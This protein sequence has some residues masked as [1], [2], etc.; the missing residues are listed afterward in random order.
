MLTRSAKY[1]YDIHAIVRIASMHALPELSAFRVEKLSAQPDIIVRSDRAPTR[2][3][4]GIAGS[5]V[6]KIVKYHDGLARLGFDIRIE[7]GDSILVNVSKLIA[8]S[9]HVLYTN[10][11]EPLLRWTF[12]Q[13]GYVLLHAACLSFNG[14]A[15]LIT[16]KTDTGKTSTIILT[17]K[18]S[19]NCEFLSDDMTILSGEC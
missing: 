11:I 4:T 19:N 8:V 3:S 12:V 18:H 16:A 7:Y 10:V 1:L 9:T 6:R 2:A 5:N 13:K 17:C 14:R 15:T